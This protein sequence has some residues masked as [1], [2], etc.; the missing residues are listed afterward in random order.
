M[1]E[2]LRFNASLRTVD[3]N[4]GNSV[5]VQTANLLPLG[6]RLCI[7][8][9]LE[10]S[11]PTEQAPRDATQ[12]FVPFDELSP[13]QQ[14]HLLGQGHFGAVF[15]GELR[16]QPCCIKTFF[17]VADPAQRARNIRK[18][19]S[20]LA[21]INELDKASFDTLSSTS[22]FATGFSIAPGNSLL[23]ILP[24]MHGSL[25]QILSACDG[26]ERA[27]LI[28]NIAESLT[29]LHVAGILHRD[30]A[31]RNM[32]LNK[33]VIQSDSWWPWSSRETV[34][35]AQMCDF[36]LSCTREAIWWSKSDEG[37]V[38][39]WPP[40]VLNHGMHQYSTAAD[41]WSFGLLLA[42]SLRRG[43]YSDRLVSPAC[44]SWLARYRQPALDIQG[45]I[46]ALHESSHA[47]PNARRASHV[48]MEVFGHSSSQD[49]VHQFSAGATTFSLNVPLLASTDDPAD[50]SILTPQRH[51]YMPQPPHARVDTHLSEPSVSEPHEYETLLPESAPNPYGPLLSGGAAS[52]PNPYGPLPSSDSA[53][54]KHHTSLYSSMPSPPPARGNHP[55]MALQMPSG[56]EVKADLDV[57]DDAKTAVPV[58][59]DGES[60]YLQMRP[61]ITAVNEEEVVDATAFNYTQFVVDDHYTTLD[62]QLEPKNDVSSS[63]ESYWLTC[64]NVDA[65]DTVV[66]PPMLH[67]LLP[68]LVHWCTRVNPKERPSMCMLAVVLD[69]AIHDQPVTL[70]PQL[71]ACQYLHRSGWTT[72]D[73]N[74]VT[75]LCTAC[76]KLP[77]AAPHGGVHVHYGADRPL[78]PDG[79]LLLSTFLR[80]QDV[81]IVTL[82]LSHNNISDAMA[83]EIGRALQNNNSL[84]T[85]NLSHNGLS[86]VG[87]VALAEGL[88]FSK[89][90]VLNLSH[91]QINDAGTVA[92]VHGLKRLLS[93][94]E[95]SLQGNPIGFTGVEA[96]NN[97]LG[98]KSTI[99]EYT[100]PG[101]GLPPSVLESS[102]LSSCGFFEKVGPPLTLILFVILTSVF[103]YQVGVGM[104]NHL[105][106]APIASAGM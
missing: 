29:C 12:Y 13:R 105:R 94:T 96:L 1:R 17:A 9:L 44:L 59:S 74:F 28:Q 5:R 18:E 106:N 52:A 35:L 69:M 32:L 70:W 16:G 8:Q 80:A 66:L 39:V 47:L 34:T 63:H 49:S 99:T 56:C 83:K 92:L 71:L 84:L 77:L 43:P 33:V 14:W 51:I 103:I 25:Q 20:E 101:E 67:T 54:K 95:L 62:L 73:A 11:V 15:K 26:R 75:E 89:L 6:D 81:H 19:V 78:S 58:R 45:L 2:A 76:L 87:A 37:P 104:I 68:F 102:L 3:I 61:K 64:V 53:H 24:L 90:Q 38:G 85:L 22:V 55:Y 65:R 72:A 48:E 30:I 98:A 91:N 40:E 36:G 46:R 4:L 57:D 60:I 50:S 27:R 82:D 21:L 23:V 7:R 79:I 93:I 86:D 10:C 100:G 97:Y 42:N 88:Q 31:A 41:V